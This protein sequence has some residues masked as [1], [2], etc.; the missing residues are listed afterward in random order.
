MAASLG[1]GER[2]DM[3]RPT[4]DTVDY[5][6]HFCD[7]GK[8]MFIIEQ[9]YGNDGYAFW[10]KLLELLGKTEG[11]FIDYNNLDDWEFLQAIT[12]LQADKCQE[13]LDKLALLGAIDKFLWVEKRIVWSDNFVKN[14]A[15]AYKNRKRPVPQ[16]PFLQVEIPNTD[17]NNEFL[18]VETPKISSNTDVSTAEKPQSI[19]KENKVNKNIVNNSKTHARED[20]TIVDNFSPD[21]FLE[22]I[23]LLEG[24]VRNEPDMDVNGEV[25]ATVERDSDFVRFL[26]T[27]PK[28]GNE[29]IAAEAWNT[30]LSQGVEAKHLILA[31]NKYTAK[32]RMDKTED[33]FIKQA[34]NFLLQGVYRDYLPLKITHC[35][36]CKEYHRCK[37]QEWYWIDVDDG[38]GGVKQETVVCPYK[39]GVLDENIG[40]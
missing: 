36:N 29:S 14:V 15:D 26:N 12:K 8:T 39:A 9:N 16:K 21:N 4:K 34:H 24:S 10:F 28:R 35:P 7:H 20:E 2:Q 32:V 17:S 37:G 25:A 18:P 19:V 3:A 30:L 40:A 38:R 31:A 23:A 1:R 27:Y 6:P 11:H 22:G 33:K 5:F 13:I